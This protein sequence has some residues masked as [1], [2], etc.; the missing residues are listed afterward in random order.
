MNKIGLKKNYK[1]KAIDFKVE[2]DFIKSQ[3]FIKKKDWDSTLVYSM[4]Q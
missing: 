2:A 3:S 4:R 1:T